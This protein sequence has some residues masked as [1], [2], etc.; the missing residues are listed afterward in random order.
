MKTTSKN[1]NELKSKSDTVTVFNEKDSIIKITETYKE[2]VKYSLIA[3]KRAIELGEELQTVKD[4][5]PHG[6]FIPWI[7]KNVPFI[8]E[9]TARRYI[10]IYK[11]QD[12]LREKLGDNLELKKAYELLNQK[13]EK[14]I[15]K[16]ESQPEPSTIDLVKEHNKL[17]AK[18]KNKLRKKK[19]LPP[20]EIRTEV[21]EALLSDKEKE[22]I[23]I[24][25]ANDLIKKSISKLEEIQSDLHLLETANRT[26]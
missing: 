6:A 11:K 24:Q 12:F 18:N 1:K 20:P 16:I 10:T 14:V 17:V 25:K 26:P 4:N 8:S 23:R 7:K 13:K 5:K 21:K 19:I 22:E 2:L 3:F 15:N 9:R